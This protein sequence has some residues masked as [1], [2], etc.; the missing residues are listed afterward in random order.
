[1]CDAFTIG[2]SS[3]WLVGVWMLTPVI[4][5]VKWPDDIQGQLVA[6]CRWWH[7]S[8][9]SWCDNMPSPGQLDQQAE[10][11]LLS[12]CGSPH[13]RINIEDPHEWGIAPHIHV[14]FSC[15]QPNSGCCFPHFSQIHG[16]HFMT[17][18]IS[19]VDSN[20]L[21]M[22]DT[23]SYTSFLTDSSWGVTSWVW[24]S[25][26]PSCGDKCWCWVHGCESLWKV[27]LLLAVL[28]Q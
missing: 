7:C 22:A 12:Y 28:A 20:M 15:Q 9:I 8:S 3:I 24:E 18:W 1:M 14:N 26:P 19:S 23:I 5:Q 6:L 2:A 16:W 10:L 27:A 21:R 11:L 25:S 13:L 17:E 4:W